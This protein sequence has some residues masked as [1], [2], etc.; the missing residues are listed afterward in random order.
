VNAELKKMAKAAK[1]QKAVKAKKQKA[2]RAAKVRARKQQKA[3]ARMI[4]KRQPV[5]LLNGNMSKG[6]KKQ[7]KDSLKKLSSKKL[8]KAA[9]KL[10]LDPIKGKQKDRQLRKLK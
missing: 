7:G 3:V 10:K 8:I 2:A 4:S 1:K 9:S 6:K 5:A